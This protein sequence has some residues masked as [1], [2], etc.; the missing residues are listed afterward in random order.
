[1]SE[2]DAAL[3]EAAQLCQEGMG[4]MQFAGI[5]APR[6]RDREI[7]EARNA[8]YDKAAKDF[9]ERIRLMKSGGSLS[10]KAALEHLIGA[11]DHA[12]RGGRGNLVTGRDMLE[13][14]RFAEAGLVSLEA[15]M[16]FGDNSLPPRV[17]YYIGLTDQGRRFLSE[18]P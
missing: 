7:A 11:S 10:P 5:A 12:T 13:A 17:C 4:F 14:L 1:M 8:G 6:K 9:A 3:E 15:I 16:P 18:E 2:R